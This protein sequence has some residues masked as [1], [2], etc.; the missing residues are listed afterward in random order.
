MIKN[1]N[2][3][4]GNDVVNSIFIEGDNSLA[5]VDTG[6]IERKQQL[7]DEISKYKY[8]KLFIIISHAHA[9]H[10]GNSFAIKEQFN[11]VFISNFYS[12]DLLEDYEYQYDKIVGSAKDHYDIDDTT[13]NWYFGLI[14]KAVDIDVSFY[15]NMVLN[16]GDRQLDLMH[17]PG[18]TAGDMGMVDKEN[19]VLIVSELIFKHS[20]EMIIYIEDY[21]GYIQSLDKI[22][23]VVNEYGIQSLYTAHEQNPIEGKENILEIIDYNRQYINKL[24]SDYENLYQKNNSLRETAAGICKMYS[25]SYTFD[26]VITGKALLG[27]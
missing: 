21:E 7:L 16:L 19:R 23:G 11:P 3:F 20:R 22:E 6:V 10:I 12:K 25:K 4:Y 9:D 18:H 1:F 14:D 24:K 17:L 2:M 5:I 27:L 26:S 13:R 15:D 8:S